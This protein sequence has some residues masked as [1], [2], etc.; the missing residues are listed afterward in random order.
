MN[1][2]KSSAEL[3]GMAKE[4]LFG[5]YGTAVGASFIVTLIRF[6]MIMLPAFM[7]DTT[8]IAGLV[9]YYMISFILSLLT[10]IFT[11]GS[12]FFYL[13]VSCR[14]NVTVGDIFSGFKIHPDKAI[15][16]QLVLTLL[17]YVCTAPIFVFNYLFA[18]TQNVVYLLLMS[19]VIIIGYVIM[20]ILN[21]ILSQI[22]FL[23]QDFPQYPVKELLKMS[24]QIMKGHKGRLFYI[25][26]SMLPLF[27]LGLLSCCIAYLWIVPYVNAVMANFYMDLMKN[28]DGAQ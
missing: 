10:G 3:K 12:S 14:Q 24:R 15:I 23:L 13:K 11:S 18:Q 27:L 22:F 16:L 7:I 5:K 17:S 25:Q 9:I 2:Y 28:R 21:L 20:I 6:V 19:V 26:L 1:K 4:Q 8:S